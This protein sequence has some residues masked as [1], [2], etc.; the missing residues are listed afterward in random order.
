MIMIF[1]CE[2][3]YLMLFYFELFR[4]IAYMIPI[5]TLLIILFLS[6]LTTRI[7]TIALMHTGMSKQMARFQARSALSTCGFTTSEAEQIMNHPVR[8]RVIMVLMLL[9]NI[10]VI[11]VFSSLILTF[12]HFNTDSIPVYIKVLT[13]IGGLLLLLF[14][15]TNKWVEKHLAIVIDFFLDKYT[16]FKTGNFHH[17]LHLH[18][19]HKIAEFALNS[20][21]QLIG[22]TFKKNLL[23]KQGVLVLGIKRSDG[24]YIG[25]PEDNFTFKANDLLTVYGLK[26]DLEVVRS[27]VRP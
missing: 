22:E 23:R 19:D 1:F 8:R 14:L 2:F 26:K 7:A 4:Y 24:T 20:N 11:T 6:L 17:L 5:I 13:L 21:S 3:L 18:D 27:F 16:D 10:G 25:F 12:I 15:T 9:G